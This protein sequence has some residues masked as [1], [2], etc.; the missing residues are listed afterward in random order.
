M[1]DANVLSLPEQR[2]LSMRTVATVRRAVT[3][4]PGNVRPDVLVFPELVGYPFS[5]R[6]AFGTQNL[7]PT[8]V[9]S[10]LMP[11]VYTC[12]PAGTH[13]LSAYFV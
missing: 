3:R 1:H 4:R 10:C 7:V 11:E 13:L 12:Y 5:S 6:Q 9:F 2:V 8:R